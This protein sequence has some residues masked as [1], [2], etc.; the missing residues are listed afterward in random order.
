MRSR[1]FVH[2]E[3]QHMYHMHVT[4]VALRCT[5]QDKITVLLLEMMRLHKS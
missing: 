4:T 5:Q 1:T 2:D 3:S